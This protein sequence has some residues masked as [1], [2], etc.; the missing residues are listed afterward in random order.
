MKFRSP[1]DLIFEYKDAGFKRV[2]ALR[3]MQTSLAQATDPKRREL[4]TQS[5][6][7]LWPKL[8]PRETLLFPQ[9]LRDTSDE[10]DGN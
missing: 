7:L 4:L 8:P 5:I 9:D 1:M 2:A 3:D 10:E 6:E